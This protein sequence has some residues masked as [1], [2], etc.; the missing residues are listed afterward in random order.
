MLSKRVTILI[1][2]I[3]VAFVLI[4]TGVYLNQ[5]NIATT[6]KHQ[7]QQEAIKAEA[8]KEITYKGKEGTTAL[9]LLE[10]FGKIEKSGAGENSFVTS[11][12][13]LKANAAKNEFWSFNVNGAPATVGAGSFITKNTDTITWK[14]DSF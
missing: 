11:I 6:K 1:S 2:S 4:I 9:V 3:P 13:G 7:A 10:Q 14:I 8:S 12:N 5:S